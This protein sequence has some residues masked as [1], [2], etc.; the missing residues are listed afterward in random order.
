MY[1][2]CDIHGKTAAD[3]CRL[4]AADEDATPAVLLPRN[5]YAGAQLKQ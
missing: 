3:V 2:I 1:Y 5:A 4:Q